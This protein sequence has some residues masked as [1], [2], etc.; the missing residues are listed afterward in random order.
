MFDRSGA[1]GHRSALP[2]VS[3]TPVG[4]TIR[5]EPFVRG[6]VCVGDA[7]GGGV[8]EPV[9][10]QRVGFAADAAG[11]DQGVGVEGDSVPVLSDQR[12]G[13]GHRSALLL[14]L[15]AALRGD[16]G[17]DGAAEVSRHRGE[18]FGVDLP[19]GIVSMGRL[20]HPIPTISRPVDDPV[21]SVAAAVLLR[22]GHIRG[23]SSSDPLGE[24]L[25]FDPSACLCFHFGD[26]LRS[27]GGWV[28]GG[29]LTSP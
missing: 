3:L 28:G 17:H 14:P 6:P 19:S 8:R 22:V 26:L 15:H 7:G 23:H 29:H 21:D 18:S 1:I 10:S 2:V 13:R 5:V 27:V 24:L 12:R 16:V 11:Q 20:D 4:A 9:G 25:R